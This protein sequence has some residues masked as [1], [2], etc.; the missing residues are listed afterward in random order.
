[1]AGRNNISSNSIDMKITHDLTVDIYYFIVEMFE[2]G[3][4]PHF[5]HIN[6]DLNSLNSFQLFYL[7]MTKDLKYKLEIFKN[8]SLSEDEIDDFRNLSGEVL[9]GTFLRNHYKCIKRT[10]LSYEQRQNIYNQINT[11]IIPKIDEFNEIVSYHMTTI[12]EPLCLE[13]LGILLWQTF[14]L[15][16]SPYNLSSTLGVPHW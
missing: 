7:D 16:D 10:R 9:N 8:G 15:F 11:F 5:D 14:G 2:K 6:L 4:S 3:T 1:M 13:T 12:K